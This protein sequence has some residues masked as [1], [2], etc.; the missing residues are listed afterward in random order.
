[1]RMGTTEH[2]E[3]NF[4]PAN[5]EIVDYF[6]NK[7]PQ[8]CGQPIEAWKSEIEAWKGDIERVYG[9]DWMKKIHRCEHCHNTNVRYIVAVRDK[10]T[11]EVI[12]FGDIC[13]AKLSFNNLDE[14]RTAQIRSLA[15]TRRRRVK[16]WL[17]YKQYLKDNPVVKWAIREIDKEVHTNNS[18]AHNVLGKLRMYGY[19]SDKQRDILVKSL[20]D[21]CRRAEEK[22]NRPESN[23]VGKVGERLEIDV[24]VYKVINI[25]NYRL[26]FMRDINGNELRWF[27]KGAK[28]FEEGDR[29]RIRGTVK[30]HNEYREV[31]QTILIRVSEINLYDND[32][33]QRGVI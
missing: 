2:T 30:I 18:F 13:A 28:S 1:M 23:Y 5:Y 33:R 4:D 31:K 29:V 26:H 7:H 8:Y 15:D 24:E 6:D 10:R 12:T 32:L 20:K 19:L 17:Q 14:Y 27:A 11:D 21:D 3:K 25:S 9:P 16:V 22:K